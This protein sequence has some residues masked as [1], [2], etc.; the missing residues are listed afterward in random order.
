MCEHVRECVEVYLGDLTADDVLADI[1]LLAEV[2]ELL[3]LG[4]ALGTQAAG[5]DGVGQ[6]WRRYSG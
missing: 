6:P 3:D 2:E 1:V 5:L 4:S